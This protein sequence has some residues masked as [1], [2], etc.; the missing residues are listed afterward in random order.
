MAGNGEILYLRRDDVAS[1]GVTYLAMIDE[2]ERCYRD[3]AA[4][5]AFGHPKVV[6]KT[7][8]GSYFFSLNAWSKRLGLN[9]CHNSMGVLAELA[10]PGEH[11]LNGMAVLSDYRTGKPVAFLDTFWMSTWS[12]AATSGAAA[13]KLA[14]PDSRSIGF[15]ATGAQAR[16]HLPALKAVLPRLD[17][18]IAY[19]RSRTGA[20]AFAAEAHKEGWQVEVTEDPRP[21]AEADVVVTS[22]PDSKTSAPMLDPAWVKPGAFVSLVDCGRAWHP[23]LETCERVMTDEHAQAA[24]EIQIGRFKIPGPFEADLKDLATGKM[25]PRRS[26]TERAVACHSG[27]SLGILA[28]AALIYGAAKQNGL[29][30]RLRSNYR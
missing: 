6:S 10:P 23:G 18:V 5:E 15:V 26:A 8:D 24:R 7:P 28:L 14:R 16:V 12:P 21:A 30:T 2:L 11:H 25:P 1:S 27:H 29:G 4:G 20:E 22:L 13:R 17:R 19:N 9:I 3:W